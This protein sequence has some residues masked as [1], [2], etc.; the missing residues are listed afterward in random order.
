M[1]ELNL[2]V[3]RSGSM[4][5]NGK[6]SIC[7]SVIQ[8]LRV[9]KDIESKFKELVINKF[10]FGNVRDDFEDLKSK[11]FLK[12]TIILTDGY[13]FLD[14]YKGEFRDFLKQNEKNLFF[15]LCGSD[16]IDLSTYKRDFPSVNCYRP[17]DIN[18]VLDMLDLISVEN[19]EKN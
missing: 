9:I 1:K 10:K 14:N 17:E 19:N 13:F 11:I 15:I 8:S 3:D 5:T 6:D 4:E 16:A 7:L 2:I 12:P 18:Y